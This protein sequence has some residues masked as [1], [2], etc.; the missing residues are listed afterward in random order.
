M[1][2]VMGIAVV[3]GAIA[4]VVRKH[5]VWWAVSAVFGLAVV[6]I[7]LQWVLPGP[8]TG[9]LGISPA[10]GLLAGAGVLGLSRRLWPCVSVFIAL[11]VVSD[12]G[13]LLWWIEEALS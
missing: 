6:Q 9:I 7:A 3:G 1:H 5:V 2:A 10:I 11:L 13:F 4:A 12:L 8:T